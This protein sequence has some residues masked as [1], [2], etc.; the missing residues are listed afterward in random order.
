LPFTRL[1]KLTLRRSRYVDKERKRRVASSEEDIRG[2]A[3]WWKHYHLQYKMAP[4]LSLN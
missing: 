1:E 4:N 3:R 2:E